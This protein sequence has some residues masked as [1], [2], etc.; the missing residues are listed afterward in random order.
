MT[1]KAAEHRLTL[2]VTARCAR[3]GKGTQAS[4]NLCH[5]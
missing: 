1:S 4:S 3:L 5:S 2:Y